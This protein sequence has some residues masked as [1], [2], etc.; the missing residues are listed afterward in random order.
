MNP[1][2]E[3]WSAVRSATTL[4]QAHD[5]LV[6]VL[7]SP[8]AAQVQWLDFHR[9]SSEVYRRIAEVDRGR[10]REARFLAE[11]HRE[12]AEKVAHALASG[13]T[14]RAASRQAAVVAEFNQGIRLRED[15]FAKAMR[16]A[17][18]RSDYALAKAM[19]LHR[20]TL[21]RVRAGELRPGGR[22]IS[23][24]LK[25]LAPFDFEDLFEVETQE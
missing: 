9:R 12:K 11:L 25:A 7:P 8:E 5:T 3:L 1:S 24:A 23:G 13:V 20:S 22:F 17:A 16:L 15:M 2:E 19:G 14:A 21:K 6:K 10:R 4:R 18:F